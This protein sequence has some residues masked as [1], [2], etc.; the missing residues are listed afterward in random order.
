M[1]MQKKL[2]SA[3]SF[4]NHHIAF[5][6]HIHAPAQ[7]TINIIPV[8]QSILPIPVSGESTPPNKNIRNPNSAEAF[9]EFLRSKSRASVVELGSISPKKM[10]KKNSNT[11]TT[12]TE[13]LKTRAAATG[14][15]IHANPM[16]PVRNAV[17]AFR[18]CDTAK[19]PSMIPNA[20]TPKQKL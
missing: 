6:V 2:R 16:T 5:L 7:Q 20:L 15:L 19:L 3:F 4:F 10:R 8:V 18:K 12:Q 11:S 9:P 17:L 1:K 13:G 14:K